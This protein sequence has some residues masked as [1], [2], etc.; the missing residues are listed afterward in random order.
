ML[1]TLITCLL[2][3]FN[4]S[5]YPEH[6]LSDSSY[7]IETF[8]DS[9]ANA[10]M[11]EMHVPGAVIT[12]VKDGKT[13][14]NKGYGYA[15]IENNI[16]VDPTKSAFRMASISKPFT[17]IAIMKLVEERKL[18]LHEDI[19][20]MIRD[21]YEFDWNHPLTIHHIMTHTTGID[22][23]SIGSHKTKGEIYKADEK[24]KLLGQGHEPG[25]HFGYSNMAFGILGYLI[26]KVSGQSYHSYMKENILDPLEMY[27]STFNTILPAAIHENKSE[28]FHWVD[29]KNVKHVRQHLGTPAASSLESTGEDMSIFMN[30]ILDPG[31]FE[32]RGIISVQSFEQM[33]T[34]QLPEVTGHTIGYA[35][36]LGTNRNT[37][38]I[39]HS[40]G[41]RGFLSVYIVFPSENLGIFI[42]QN[43]RYG[44]EYF[45]WNINSE[46]YRKLLPYKKADLSWVKNQEDR[47]IPIQKFEGYYSKPMQ[48]NS[49][50][51]KA[52]QLLMNNET[53]VSI[54]NDS[55]LA[56][57]DKEF[58]RIGKTTFLDTRENSEFVI[59]FREGKTGEIERMVNG[60]ESHFKLKWYERILFIQI[61]TGLCFLIFIARFVSNIYLFKTGN[62]N[63][64]S[65]F[66]KWINILGGGFLFSFSALLASYFIVE[67]IKEGVPLGFKI[68]I[69]FITVLSFFSIGTP[70][71]LVK[72]IPSKS[73]LKQKL[74]N[75]IGIAAIIFI[76]VLFYDLN[77]VGF[78][79]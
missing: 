57:F 50:F 19:R 18:K 54:V 15:D 64:N 72:T 3:N 70:W 6:A 65:Q 63:K 45:A 59:Q 40:G 34:P 51:E 39:F 12:I 25:S 41:V 74:W 5:A 42:C 14:F 79:W 35:F 38:S 75:G 67:T 27:H 69:L 2:F 22:Y 26:E 68:P 31:I 66:E 76:A 55:T 28:T 56:I 17:A 9:L 13:V 24:I 60:P 78:K 29:G 36:G 43:N 16:T 23:S 47:S 58:K 10:K 49:T 20:P 46:L 77:L 8:I 21:K 30:A 62:E 53:K 61:L 4:S 7:H 1:I 44:A 71:L 73:N 11:S 48:S 52:Q 33:T 32:E 37:S